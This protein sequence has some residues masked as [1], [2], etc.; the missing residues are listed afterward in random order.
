MSFPPKF[1]R[2]SPVTQ[3]SPIIGNRVSFTP[4]SSRH[5][6]HS[7][8]LIRVSP[9]SSAKL[10]LMQCHNLDGVTGETRTTCHVVAL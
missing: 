3:S 8:R 10:V 9:I 4:W 6:V 5:Y 1:R 2:A 7:S